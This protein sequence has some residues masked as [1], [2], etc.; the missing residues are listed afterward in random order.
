MHTYSWGRQP[1]VREEFGFVKAA[2]LNSGVKHTQRYGR[3]VHDCKNIRLREC[4]SRR[5]A[6]EQRYAAGMA[7]THGWQ[8]ETC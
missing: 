7:D 2:H 1:T 3:T 5:I 4:P 6:V 8:F